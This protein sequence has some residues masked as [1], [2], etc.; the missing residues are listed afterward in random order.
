MGKSKVVTAVFRALQLILSI[1]VLALTL[2]F[3]KGQVYGDPP[4]TTKF[5]IFVAAFTIVVAVAN[6]LGAIWW[7]WLEDIVPT[8]ALMALDGIAALLVIA[9][10]IAWSIGLKDTHGCSLGDDDGRGLYFTGLING[11]LIDVGGPQ[12]LAGYLR[13]E[14]LK[15]PDLAFSRLQGLCHKAV[16]NQSLMFVVGVALCGSLIGL[17]FWSYK[18]GGQKTTYV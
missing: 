1:T 9:A 18:R 8:I 6:L 16:A 14:D 13:E 5:T 17:R 12:P 15:S 2:T 3:L 11:G 7:T 10:G 4:T